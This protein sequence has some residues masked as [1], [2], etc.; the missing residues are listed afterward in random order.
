MTDPPRMTVEIWSDVICPFC[1]I[2]K[3]K[4]ESALATLP[5]RRAEPRGEEGLDPGL[6]PPGR[7]NGHQRRALFRLRPQVHGQRCPGHHD[8]RPGPAA[9]FF[10]M[11]RRHRFAVTSVSGG[12][13]RLRPAGKL[14]LAPTDTSCAC[15]SSI[16]Y[17]PK[18]PTANSLGER[19]MIPGAN[20]VAISVP[21]STWP[22]TSTARSW[23]LRRWG[24]RAGPPNEPP[25]IY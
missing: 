5:E 11:D 7:A 22:W 25:R 1:Y 9:V 17:M 12:R 3:R 2:G 16:C 23:V 4:F 19:T 13:R 24:G 6:R 14:R 21:G 15:T 8:L 10:R 18:T 20:Y